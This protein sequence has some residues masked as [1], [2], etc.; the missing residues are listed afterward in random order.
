M[1][2]KLFILNS[3]FEGQPNVLIEALNY[4]LPII[5]TDCESGPNEIL[6]NGKF[7]FLT[8]IDN[9]LLLSKKISYALENYIL[10][11][12]KSKLGFKSLNRFDIKTQCSKYEKYIIRFIK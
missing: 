7:G 12:N 1:S 8:S 3:F 10:A 5:S 9:P 4:K 11:K 6:S 2:S